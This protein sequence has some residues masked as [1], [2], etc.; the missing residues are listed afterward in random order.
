MLVFKVSHFV[1]VGEGREVVMVVY[2]GGSVGVLMRFLWRSLGMEMGV[3]GG[4][5]YVLGCGWVGKWNLDKWHHSLH[6][7]THY[8][9]EYIVLNS[10]WPNGLSGFW[11]N[12]ICLFLLTPTLHIYPCS[13]SSKG[14]CIQKFSMWIVE[15]W[16]SDVCNQSC[17]GVLKYTIDSTDTTDIGKIDILLS[18]KVA[19]LYSI[20]TSSCKL[21]V[22]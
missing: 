16:N 20:Y 7:N 10:I 4:L 11:K 9:H 6:A 2:V 15:I 19:D 13:N 12:T 18:N 3:C 14:K 22:C 21:N 1:C 8:K 5:V 17:Q